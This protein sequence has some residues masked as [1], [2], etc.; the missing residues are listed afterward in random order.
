MFTNRYILVIID[1]LCPQ[2]AQCWARIAKSDMEIQRYIK[3][4]ILLAEKEPTH[5]FQSRWVTTS[6]LFHAG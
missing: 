4:M 3:L 2:N 6:V 1:Y 5:G